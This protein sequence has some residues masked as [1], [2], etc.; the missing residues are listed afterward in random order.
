MTSHAYQ[1]AILVLSKLEDAGYEAMLV[2]GCVRDRLL[3]LEPH[4]YDIATSAKPSQVMTLFSS[5]PGF[6]CVETGV[7]FGTVT[8]VHEKVAVEVTT[9]RKDVSPD[10]R[11]TKVVYGQN[12]IEDA[13]RRDFT[14]NALYEDL[15]GTVHDFVGGKED[16]ERRLIRFVGDPE[17][18]IREDFLRALRYFRFKAR[19]ELYADGVTYQT[20]HALL[21]CV[22]DLSY[23]RIH[24]EWRGIVGCPNLTVSIVEEWFDAMLW[25]KIWK[26]DQG[27]ARFE[28]SAQSIVGIVELQNLSIDPSLLANLRLA[29]ILTLDPFLSVACKRQLIAKLKELKFSRLE[30]QQV[31]ELVFGVSSLANQCE[32]SVAQI[33]DFVAL[34]ETV[35]GQ[36]SFVKVVAPAWRLAFALNAQKSLALDNIVEVERS[37]GHRRKIAEQVSGK[38]L[39]ALFPTLSGKIVGI[40]MQH[41]KSCILNGAWSP[42]G[43]LSTDLNLGLYNWYKNLV[44]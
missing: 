14:V 35:F 36:G 40:S 33:L 43:E 31:T 38:S 28:C 23:E 39:L 11:W 4:D 20:V 1:V 9:L 10:G 8:V 26:A 15:R 29:S 44:E 27:L 22:A 19:Y 13:K 32:Q 17:A 41:V 21:T 18:R 25:R 3:G 30:A 24:H 5:V 34:F 37:C 12:F 42:L 6:S 2:G 16:L 7:A